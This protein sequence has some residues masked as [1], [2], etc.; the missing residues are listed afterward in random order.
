ML[1]RGLT[2][3]GKQHHSMVKAALFGAMALGALTGGANIANAQQGRPATRGDTS[4][5]QIP[6]DQLPI[7]QRLQR[8]P[9]ADPNLPGVASPQINTPFKLIWNFFHGDIDQPALR[10]VDP[11]N[12]PNL[13]SADYLGWNAE[14]SLLV[15]DDSKVYVWNYKKN[16]ITERYK[17]FA[18]IPT[19][20]LAS[21]KNSASKQDYLASRGQKPAPRQEPPVQVARNQGPVSDDDARKA[22]GRLSA[23]QT[24]RPSSGVPG[25]YSATGASLKGDTLTLTLAD[26]TKKSL[27]VE[28]PPTPPGTAAT[29]SG[30]I[31]GT[32]LAFDANKIV[33]IQGD[34][35][36]T[37]TDMDPRLRAGFEQI[38]KMRD[39]R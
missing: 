30:D 8:D 17:S 35:R 36:A 38:K 22:L 2:A 21:L 33:V 37:V 19:D 31:A 16:S 12:H 10:I 20:V 26:G 23:G 9:E 5:Q 1:T 32:W 4:A 3:G 34:G 15:S 27:K 28:R 14:G 24:V 39:Q 25:G 18:A 11:Q 7:D 29:A 6:L 13:Y